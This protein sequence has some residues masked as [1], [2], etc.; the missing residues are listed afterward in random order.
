[1][2]A[3]QDVLSLYTSGRKTGIVLDADDGISPIYEGMQ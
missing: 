1:L 3:F 2:T